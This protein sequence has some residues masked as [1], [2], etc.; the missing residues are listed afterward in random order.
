[1]EECFR[2]IRM[3]FE[4]KESELNSV[5]NILND[6][7]NE[8]HVLKQKYIKLEEDFTKQKEFW[9][10]IQMTFASMSK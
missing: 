5:K 8:L 1:M 6:R 3:K 4:A 2:Q 10:N 9:N 7:N